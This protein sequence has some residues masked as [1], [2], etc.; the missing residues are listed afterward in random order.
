MRERQYS[1]SRRR[2]RQILLSAL[3]ISVSVS[4]AGAKQDTLTS[5]ESGMRFF[6]AKHYDIASKYFEQ[7][8]RQNPADHQS[9]VY[10]AMC[11]L[12]LGDKERARA[13]F[14]H[15]QAVFPTS[16]SARA[17]Q[18][19]LRMLA[20]SPP[21]APATPPPTAAAAVSVNLA[22]LAAATARS[23]SPSKGMSREQMIAAINEKIAGGRGMHEQGRFKEA[24]RQFIDALAMSE[25]LGQTSPELA[26]SLKAY[27]DFLVDLKE[28]DRAYKLY[29]RE[30]EIRQVVWGQQSREVIDCMMRIA[31]IYK[32]VGDI[33]TAEIMYRKCH[34]IF[35]SDYDTAMRQRK[36]VVNERNALLNCENGLLAILEIRRTP[37]N[38]GTVDE[39]DDLKNKIKLLNEEAQAAPTGK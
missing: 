12:K 20:S 3:L 27:A 9:L 33:D 7:A 26:N 28:R 39:Y 21:P 1:D 31:P 8:M 38:L 17:A 10:D 25:K 13:L 34:P 4:A 32:D 37:H 16:S 35:Q 19:G 36:R 23:S 29:K 15:V 18:F 2:Q 22:P 14:R 11:Y 5:F 30:L 24:E 6:N